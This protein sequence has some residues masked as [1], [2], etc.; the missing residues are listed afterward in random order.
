MSPTEFFWNAIKRS[1]HGAWHLGHTVHFLIILF[2]GTCIWIGWHFEERKV[3]VLPVA[4]LVIAVVGG[5][6]WHAYV[7]YRE[8]FEKRLDAE[9]RLAAAEKRIAGSGLDAARRRLAEANL[10]NLSPAE[11]E[12]LRQI[13]VRGQVTESQLAEQ[14]GPP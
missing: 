7:I 12:A 10:A 3:I 6:L 11:E 5:L 14:L 2:A 8:E 4:V 13:L 9:K 1:V